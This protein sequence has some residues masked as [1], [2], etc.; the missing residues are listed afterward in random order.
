MFEKDLARGAIPN[1]QKLFQCRKNLIFNYFYRPFRLSIS[2]LLA[3]IINK[4]L[5][6]ALLHNVNQRIKIFDL[7]NVVAHGGVQKVDRKLGLTPEDA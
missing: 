2:L 6:N 4:Q 7:S 1:L 3:A 5:L